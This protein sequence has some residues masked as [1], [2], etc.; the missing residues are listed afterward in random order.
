[1]PKARLILRLEKEI[2]ESMEKYLQI[3]M[4]SHNVFIYEVITF[5][6]TL[7]KKERIRMYNSRPQITNDR[8]HIYTHTPELLKKA[9]KY[10]IA[11]LPEDGGRKI[12]TSD[13][14]NVAIYYFL[15]RNIGKNI[16]DVVSSIVEKE[17]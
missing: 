4:M 6:L 5:W 8:E 10:T 15:Q 13:V 2:K 16:M 1:M 17:E 9:M 12:S 7:S 14:Y 3:N 11:D